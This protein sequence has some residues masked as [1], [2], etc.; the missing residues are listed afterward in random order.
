MIHAYTKYVY[1]IRYINIS[2]PS[3]SLYALANGF[4]LGSVG[5][6]LVMCVGETGVM[7]RHTCTL[8]L[9]VE[10]TGVSA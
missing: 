2:I 1:T 5:M 4:A 9:C 6:V 7:K 8:Q 3:I 10:E